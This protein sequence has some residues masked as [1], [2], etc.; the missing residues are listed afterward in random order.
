MKLVEQHCTH[1]APALDAGAVNA[2]L[3]A[4]PDWRL[5]GKRIE[6]E[7]AFTD[8]HETIAFV[9]ALAAM[10][11]Q[12]DHHPELR[13]RYRHCLVAFT[14]HSAGNAVSMNDFICAAKADAIYEER[15]A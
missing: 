1:G 3:A 4:L 9:D 14:T 2:H 13:V 7:Y 8:Y 6:R 5:A 12:Q 11:H 15:R 10:I